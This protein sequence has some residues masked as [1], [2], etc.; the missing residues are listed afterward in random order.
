M[1]PR[2]RRPESAEAIAV[3]TAATAGGTQPRGRSTL[4]DRMAGRREVRPGA[5][6]GAQGKTASFADEMAA[7]LKQAGR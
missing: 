6:T 3:L 1:S 7:A 4:D 5:G 2:T